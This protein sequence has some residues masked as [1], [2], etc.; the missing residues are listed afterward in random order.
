MRFTS[1][2]AVLVAISMT[3]A[4]GLIHGRMSRRWGVSEE[5]QRAGK[6][7]ETL[8]TNF[9]TWEMEASSALGDYARTVLESTGSLNRVYV[10]SETGQ[11]VSVALVVGPAGP[12]ATHSPEIC[13][14]S[15]AMKVLDE[16]KPI[17]LQLQ[18]S[19]THS[20]CGP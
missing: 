12:I 18:G 4:S 7:L 16:R 1:V 5:L 2:L 19:K 20:S 15:R 11:R 9:G 14:S 3:I 10:N 6:R 8:Q 17:S 13:F